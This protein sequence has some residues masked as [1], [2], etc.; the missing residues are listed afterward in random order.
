MYKNPGVPELEKR[1]KDKK[2]KDKPV[3]F[4]FSCGNEISVLKIVYRSTDFKAE[5][6][7]QLVRLVTE[8]SQVVLL[9]CFH[10]LSVTNLVL[11]RKHFNL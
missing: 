2:K 11:V 9:F 3:T 4:F 10:L 5:L 7:Q 8:T 1:K 6:T